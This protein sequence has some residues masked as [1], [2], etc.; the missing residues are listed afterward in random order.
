MQPGR[1][2]S[3]L[4][5]PVWEPIPWKLKIRK[6]LDRGMAHTQNAVSESTLNREMN[7]VSARPAGNVDQ[8]VQHGRSRGEKDVEG[9]F[10]DTTFNNTKTH[11]IR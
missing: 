6:M 10:Q 4:A 5:S 2:S 7:A 9:C 1:F 3:G 11:I 8:G